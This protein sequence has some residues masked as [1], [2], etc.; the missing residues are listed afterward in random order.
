M[1]QIRSINYA[2]LSVSNKEGIVEFAKALSERKVQL[3]STGG[4]AKL[5]LSA[6]LVTIE[7]ADY[8]G[9][10]EIMSGR[11]KTLHPKIYGG[12]L[13]RRGQDDKI[14]K[15]Y[16]I[17]PIDMVV[18]NLYNFIQTI[19]NK[20][21]T[22]EDTIESIDI[23]GPSMIR[24]AA[25][26]YKNV[27]IVINNKDYPRIIKE[28]DNK[29]NIITDEFRFNLAFKAFKYTAAYDEMIFN[30]FNKSAPTYFKETNQSLNKF[31]NKLNFNLIK[32]Q[33]I[34]YGENSHQD[35]AFYI[36][37]NDIKSQIY[38]AKQLQ[39]KSL[40]YNNIVDADTALECVK[41]FYKPACVIVKHAN[42]CGVAISNNIY[43]AYNYAFKTDPNSAFG[44]IIAFNRTLD[45]NTAK[46]MI[47][48]Q[49]IEVIIAPGISKEAILI[50]SDKPNIRVLIYNQYYSTN[51]NLDF[52]CVN[53][54]LLVQDRDIYLMSKDKLNIVSKRKPSKQEIE[55]SLFCW[56]VVKFVKSNAIVYAKNNITIGIGAG[57][58]SRI[59]SVKIA[60]LKAKEENLDLIGCTMASDAFFPF[61][62]SI[63]IAA[64]E[65]ITCIIQPGG[66]IRDNEII[67]AANEHNIVMIFT[68][69]RHLRH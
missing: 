58:T 68:K 67:K 47:D 1:S 33:N 59:Y 22:L 27:I 62:D 8:I 16:Q 54:G 23:G 12:I 24:A 56:Q 13:S 35:A 31:P 41:S 17:I 63:D 43:M 28:M 42:P 2:L 60:A 34:R 46:I 45:K 19:K 49:F 61:R 65:G 53:G 7:V 64:N 39:G 3:I 20:N 66:S 25:K 48:Q 6:G 69:I 32:L 40:S 9:W 5:L 52:K 51:L 29:N 57:Q 50:I 26:N 37:K 14:I 15:K 10:P 38:S 18:V 36:K 21:C 30:Y 55:N 4:T 11:V 44:G